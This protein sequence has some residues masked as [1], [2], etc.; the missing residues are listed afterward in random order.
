MLFE[1][2]IGLLRPD[3][4]IN[5]AFTLAVGVP[6]TYYLSFQLHY[7]INEIPEPSVMKKLNKFDAKLALKHDFQL[8]RKDTSVVLQCRVANISA[9]SISVK[10]VEFMPSEAFS[11]EALSTALFQLSTF[12]PG[13][14]RSYLFK[15]NELRAATS[16]EELG[17]LMV[18]WWNENGD[19][20]RVV[21]RG[22][23][24]PPKSD[25]AV[26]WSLDAGSLHVEKP[27]SVVVRVRNNSRDNAL[28]EVKVVLLESEMKGVMLSSLNTLV[29]GSI[30]PLSERT[31][32]LLAF[33]CM[34]GIQC[35]LG[36]H[37]FVRNKKVTTSELQVYVQY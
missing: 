13:E 35:L 32:E 31:V 25:G 34:T 6:D 27:S 2:L 19:I 5:Y 26:S 12:K 15:L 16:N 9:N 4:H 7:Q 20:G 29:I 36:L 28:E 23:D 1:C 18:T 11:V 17:Q 21:F 37:L 10:A 8:I 30:A 22:I 14:V 24:I 3:E 33:P